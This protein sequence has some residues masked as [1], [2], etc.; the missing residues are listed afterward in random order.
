MDARRE[1]VVD[2]I[3]DKLRADTLAVEINLGW[4]TAAAAQDFN[5][6]SFS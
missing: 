4:R 2:Q 3:A 5:P 1:S 6:M